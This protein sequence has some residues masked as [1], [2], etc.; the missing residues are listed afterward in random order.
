[1]AISLRHALI[2]IIRA[3]FEDITWSWSNASLNKDA[4]KSSSVFRANGV[5]D[6]C[7]PSGKALQHEMM[8]L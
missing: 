5:Y 2:E 4:I 6:L 1:M 7:L 3:E 8:G